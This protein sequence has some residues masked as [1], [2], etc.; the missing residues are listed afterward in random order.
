MQWPL[1]H[2]S[3]FVSPVL[4]RV[5]LGLALVV[6]VACSATADSRSMS[7]PTPHIVTP[8]PP[9][10][11][12]LSE[13]GLV[14]W[15]G[16]WHQGKLTASGERFDSRAFSAAHRSLPF[17]TVLRVTDLE[18]GRT[19]KVRINDRGPYVPGRLL[20]LSAAAARALGIGKDGVKRARIEVFASDQP[21][22]SLVTASA[23]AAAAPI[24]LSY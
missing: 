5:P 10:T 11:A 8:A 17:G 7:A 20:D 23:G 6:L 19:I 4:R 18:T 13:V 9:A 16:G 3:G 24:K 14:S 1:R 12:S 22:G 2:G 21:L 15:Y